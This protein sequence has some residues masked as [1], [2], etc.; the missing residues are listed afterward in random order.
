MARFDAV[1]ERYDAFCQT[2]LG[3]Y[4][5]AVERALVWELLDPRPGEAVA[6]LGCGTGAY[7]VSLAQAG[8]AVTGVD[9]S[10]AMLARA[11]A[12]AGANAPLTWVQADLAA[13]PLAAGTFDAALMQ[14]TLEFVARPTAVVR[15]ACRVLRPGGRLV[16]G[17]IHGTGPWARHDRR[18]AAGDPASVYRH[19]RFWTV[20]ELK[21]LV[22]V[23]P[24][25]VRAGLYVAPGE[26]RSAAEAWE[27]ERQRRATADAWTAGYVAARFDCPAPAPGEKARREQ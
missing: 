4:V 19:A 10:A 22:A 16:V 14:V 5:D 20:S 8:C 15:E 25:S 21:A 18:R 2:P 27:V 12:K 17:L 13:L 23:A 7:T 9:E 1:A 26:F 6:D 11:R 24:A 3:Q